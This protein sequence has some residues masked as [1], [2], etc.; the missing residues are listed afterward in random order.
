MGAQWSSSPVKASGRTTS[1]S[2]PDHMGSPM[3]SPIV[4]GKGSQI[5]P[6]LS[7][8][9]SQE[10][11]DSSVGGSED[12]QATGSEVSGRSCSR[13]LTAELGMQQGDN[14]GELYQTAEMFPTNISEDSPLKQSI[15]VKNYSKDLESKTQ[16]QIELYLAVPVFSDEYN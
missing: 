13:D 12:M 11:V 1:F 16:E 7:I 8:H 14:S 3:F 2:P 15:Y 5:Q 4:K 6:S 10:C 9:M